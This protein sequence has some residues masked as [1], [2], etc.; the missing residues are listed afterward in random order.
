MRPKQFTMSLATAIDP[1]GVFQDQTLGRAG[2]FTLNG[3]E[4]VD[5]EWVSPDAVAKK[6]GFESAA[7]LSAVT[8]TVTGFRDANRELPITETLAGPNANTV[9]TTNY[10]YSIQTIS[11]D[12]A[13]ASNIEAGSVDEAASR[14]L[15]LNW[16]GGNVAF[17]IAVSGT[18]SYTVQQTFDNTADEDEH[19]FTWTDHDSTALVAATTT[20]NG[21]Y[22]A[23]PRAMQ[24]IINSYTAGAS[25]EVSASQSDL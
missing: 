21:N 12:G 23:I 22:I 24:I 14:I 15:P 2:N 19:P 7:N 13:V 9:E 11:A 8:I 17:N 18:V 10:F 3:A 25:L 16:R 1:N 5:G 6:I 20:Q 4:V